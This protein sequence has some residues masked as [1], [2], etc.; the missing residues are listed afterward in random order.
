MKNIIVTEIPVGFLC[1]TDIAKNH[2][3]KNPDNKKPVS[4]FLKTTRTVNLINELKTIYVNPI[5][6]VENKNIGRKTFCCSELKEAF[7]RWVLKI[8]VNGILLKQKEFTSFLINAIGEKYTI[9]TEKIIDNYRVDLIINNKLIIEFDENYHLSKAQNIKDVKK[10]EY[11]KSI[12]Y[13]IIRHNEKKCISNVIK[14]IL[15]TL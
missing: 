11:L 10:D 6:I 14:K 13:E 7:E 9:E 1:I 15:N 5:V 3:Q 12:G 8:N 2:Y 4:E